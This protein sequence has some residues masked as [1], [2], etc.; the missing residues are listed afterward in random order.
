MN[1]SGGDPF[2]PGPYPKH[3]LAPRDGPDAIYSGLLE[4]P[5]TDRIAKEVKGGASGFENTTVSKVFKCGVATEPQTC[6]HS[7]ETAAACFSSATKMLGNSTKVTTKTVSDSSVPAGCSVSGSNDGRSATITFNSG[8]STACCSAIETSGTSKSLVELTVGVDTGAKDTVKI[9]ITGPSNVW[10]GVG[11]NATLMADKPYAI[12]IEG[13][14]GSVVERQLGSHDGKDP[15]GTVLKSTVTVVSNTVTDGLRTVVLTRPRQGTTTQ[16]YTF[17][18]SNLQIDFI[19]A[20]GSSPKFAFHKSSTAASISLWPADAAQHAWSVTGQHLQATA[21]VFYHF[22]Y[23][24]IQCVFGG[25]CSCSAGVFSI[26]SQ[27]AQPFGSASGVIHY[28]E[29]GE[30]VGFP[31]NRCP[32]QP[33]GD[34]LAQ[35]NPT[36]DIRSYTGGLSTCHHKW[37]LLDKDQAIPWAS[38]PLVYYKK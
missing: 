26:C 14:S 38:Q 21:T 12:T 20:V 32:P 25:V 17:D 24:L 29:T 15:A 16:H 34:L 23:C 37:I 11:F 5:L 33:R 13:S 19:N 4:C 3:A 31:A 10:F 2:V 6:A 28:L 30:K 35:R 9:T 27:P 22:L 7:V 18:P 8:S 1:I 36:C